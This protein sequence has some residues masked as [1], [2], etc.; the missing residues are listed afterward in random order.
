VD[1]YIHAM[2]LYQRIYTHKCI[3]IYTSYCV[4]ISG[5]FFLRIFM[6]SF[7][8]MSTLA[9]FELPFFSRAGECGV[10]REVGVWVEAAR[11][12]RATT[13]VA[14]VE[15]LPPTALAIMGCCLLWID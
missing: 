4:R 14:C 13:G 8:G 3:Y 7:I 1:V 11:A 2:R 10:T 12:T 6:Q 15:L 9:F 5:S